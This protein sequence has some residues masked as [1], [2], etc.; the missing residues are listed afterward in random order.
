MTHQTTWLITLALPLRQVSDCAL[1]R[2]SVEASSTRYVRLAHLP[3]RFWLSRQQRVTACNG[4]LPSRYRRPYPVAEEQSN[5]IK[6]ESHLTAFYVSPS[7]ECV[8]RLHNHHIKTM[9]GTK[10]V[11][12]IPCT[13]HSSVIAMNLAIADRDRSPVSSIVVVLQ[14][15]GGDTS[16]AQSHQSACPP[17][18]LQASNRLHQINQKPTLTCSDCATSSHPQLSIGCPISS[19]P[20]KVLELVFVNV[21]NTVTPIQ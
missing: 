1:C 2:D 8:A 16:R 7:N 21:A 15:L 20:S 4:L 17:R 19:L 10:M 5:A 6:V 18:K 13:M 3:G 9:P 12:W 11:V 14:T